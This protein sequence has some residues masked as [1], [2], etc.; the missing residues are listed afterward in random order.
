MRQRDNVRTARNGWAGNLLRP[1]IERRRDVRVAAV[2]PPPEIAEIIG[3][4]A[5]VIARRSR[6]PK[7]ERTE[8][9][10]A[11]LAD[12]VAGAWDPGGSVY[13]ATKTW[14]GSGLSDAFERLAAHLSP[15]E[16]RA[17]EQHMRAVLPPC[18][19]CGC[20]QTKLKKFSRSEAA[21]RAF[22]A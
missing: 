18:R 17:A 13:C 7:P 10:L 4:D 14:Y 8:G 9:S 19:N 22:S 6:A 2:A 12:Y 20:Q 15:A 21:V 16:R 1:P 3:G 11:E 5:N